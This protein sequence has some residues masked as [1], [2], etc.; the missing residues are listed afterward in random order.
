MYH[1]T[2]NDSIKPRYQFP[3]FSTYY[4]NP[5]KVPLHDISTHHK[6]IADPNKNE[7]IRLHDISTHHKVIAD[8]KKNEVITLPMETSF[9]VNNPNVLFTSTE[10]IP[11]PSMT[12]AERMNAMTRV[13][14]VIAAI[15]YGIQFP[16]WWLFLL[17]SLMVIVV[18]WFSILKQTSLEGGERHY[19]RRP[20]EVKSDPNSFGSSGKII[21][22]LDN[23]KPT[24]KLVPRR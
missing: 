10:L 4:H 22:R 8:H 12:T 24:F 13:V 20:K 6:V 14:I 5:N 17:I 16:L 18:I 15:M 11:S 1:A 2:Y 7:V 23:N 9:W 3:H 21:T 19:L